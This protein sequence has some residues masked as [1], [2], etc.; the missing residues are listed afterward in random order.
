VPISACSDAVRL[1]NN[2]RRLRC[3]TGWLVGWVVGWVVGLVGC[4]GW[5]GGWLVGWLVWLVVLVG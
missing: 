3:Y 2:K 5:L 1:C 4:F